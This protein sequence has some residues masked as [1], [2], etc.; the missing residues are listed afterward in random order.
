MTDYWKDF[1]DI[2][3][4]LGDVEALILSILE[5]S[6]FPLGEDIGK[7]VESGGKMLRP[8]LVFVGGEF[9][10]ARNQKKWTRKQKD[11]LVHI[12]AAMELLHTATLIHDDIIDRASHRRGIPTLH[13]TLGTTN[14]I[15]AGDWLLSRTYRIIAQYVQPKHA[16]VLSD[17]VSAIC[18]AEINQDLAKYSFVSSRRRYLQTIAGKTAELFSLALH[19]GALETGCSAANTQALRR[20]GYNLGM[21]F[22]II[23]DILDYESSIEELKKPVG[24]DI[25]EGLC[26]L[27][28]IYALQENEEEIRPLLSAIHTRPDIVEDVLG[29]VL[30]TKAIERAQEDA[31]HYTHL[32]HMEIG[33]LPP[34]KPRHDLELIVNSLLVR[35]Y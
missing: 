32:A 29:L 15:L 18:K 9:G 26:T 4:F 7:L 35:T 10:L 13:Q 16:V 14:A 22:Q 34:G 20:T 12:A 31:T 19:I 6:T 1:P 33:R 17:F 30:Q 3:D 25:R 21:A 2:A 5:N 8:A 11:I 27:P 28:L 23:D 24:N